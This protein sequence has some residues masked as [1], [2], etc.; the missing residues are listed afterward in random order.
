MKY[1]PDY[2]RKRALYISTLRHIKAGGKFC[3]DYDLEYL[4][5]QSTDTSLY[6]KSEMKSQKSCLYESCSCPWKLIPRSDGKRKELKRRL[7]VK[8]VEITR[9]TSGSSASGELKGQ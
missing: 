9:K 8:H 6:N 5:P 2:E 1:R 7:L 3:V 4:F